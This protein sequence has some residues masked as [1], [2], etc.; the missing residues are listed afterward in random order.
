MFLYVHAHVNDIQRKIYAGTDTESIGLK[1]VHDNAYP[2]P[3]G[4]SSSCST[5]VQWLQW[6]W[7]APQG[8]GAGETAWALATEAEPR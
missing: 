1:G 7:R 8:F 5:Q 2:T 3:Q 4:G 6:V